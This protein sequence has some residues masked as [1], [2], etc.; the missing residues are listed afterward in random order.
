[1]K[2]K[3]IYS[4][5]DILC[6]EAIIKAG[7][8]SIE[9][10]KRLKIKYKSENQP[11]TNADIEIND[12]LKKYLKEATPQYGWLSEESI[13]DNSRNKLDSYDRWEKDIE[14]SQSMEDWEYRDTL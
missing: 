12:F 14:T 10:Q 3:N 7:K 8:I 6:K 13:D 2:K 11:V 4:S 9:L 5:F 1:M